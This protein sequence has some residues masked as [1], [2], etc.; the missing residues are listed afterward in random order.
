M[1]MQEN[2]IEAYGEM[3]RLFPHL[4]KVVLLILSTDRTTEQK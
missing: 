4:W 2:D 1:L 3:K